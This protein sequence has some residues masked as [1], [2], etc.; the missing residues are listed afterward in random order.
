MQFKCVKNVIKFVFHVFFLIF[1]SK[2]DENEYTLSSHIAD[3]HDDGC[4]T[5]VGSTTTAHRP[6]SP[7]TPT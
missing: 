6:K 1:V 2:L 3:F 5:S 7:D 4:N